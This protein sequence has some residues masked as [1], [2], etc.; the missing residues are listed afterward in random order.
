[1]KQ[2]IKSA[3]PVLRNALIIFFCL[4]AFFSQSC[5]GVE[6]SAKPKSDTC[7]NCDSPKRFVRFQKRGGSSHE[8]SKIRFTHPLILSPEDWVRILDSIHVQGENPGLPFFSSKGAAEQ[9]FSPD[10]VVY[11]SKV[12]SKA[13]A[14]VQPDKLVV[15]GLSKTRS[16]G[17][18]EVTT[19]GWFV[20]GTHL[21]LL[22]ANY[23]LAVTMPSITDLLWRDPFYNNAPQFYNLAP[24]EHQTL[25]TA[26]KLLGTIMKSDI[27]NLSIAYQPLLAKSGNGENRASAAKDSTLEQRLRTLM[28]FKEKGLITEQ[29]FLEKRKKLLENF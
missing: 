6:Q 17:L 14:Q 18:N 22:L 5:L 9:A 27:P 3:P 8:Q 15:F 28:R 25:G 21:H 19:G 2:R 1:M 10:D 11:L 7:A 12:L 20:E 4:I 29:E 23:R 16:P 26:G 24:G 13:F